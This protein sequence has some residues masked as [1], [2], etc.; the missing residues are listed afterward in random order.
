MDAIEG[1]SDCT[2]L[3]LPALE[4]LPKTD[5]NYIRPLPALVLP[6]RL[7]INTTRKITPNQLYIAPLSELF[8]LQY[9]GSNNHLLTR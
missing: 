4:K 1:G 8:R 5:R 2:Q 3:R 6:L 9:S 7:L